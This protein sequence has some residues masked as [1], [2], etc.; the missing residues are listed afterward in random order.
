MFLIVVCWL[1]FSFLSFLSFIFSYCL[2]NFLNYYYFDSF[3][4]LNSLW[5][6]AYYCN[7]NTPRKIYF[8][9][10]ISQLPPSGNIFYTSSSLPV[11]I[12]SNA[13]SWCHLLDCSTYCSSLLELP[14]LSLLWE[15]RYWSTTRGW[16]GAEAA[17]LPHLR[18]SLNSV[19][20]GS[21]SS[22][23]KNILFIMLQ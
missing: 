15:D 12:S 23:I 20:A 10:K 2:S 17:L 18:L 11:L 1:F 3:D 9:Q 4:F 5:H 19:C 22:S 16:R 6:L 13:R 21:F 7:C 8:G 14:V